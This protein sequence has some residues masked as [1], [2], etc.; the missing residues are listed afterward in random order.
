M[1]KNEKPKI[2]SPTDLRLLFL[3]EEERNAESKKRKS[4]G[5]N[6]HLET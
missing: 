1:N 2:N 5:G 6:V 3:R 4:K